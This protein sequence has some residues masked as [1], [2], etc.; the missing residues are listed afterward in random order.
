MYNM[1]KNHNTLDILSSLSTSSDTGDFY[2]TKPAGY[3]TGLTRYIVITGSVMSGLGKGIFSASLACLLQQHGY[4]CNLIKMDGYFNEDAG[5]LSPYRHG[6]VFVL[7]D[8][9]E[10]DMDIGTYERFS[11]Q[12][13]SHFNIF[14][15]GRLIKRINNLERKGHFQGGDVQFY[16]HVTGE[17]LKFVRESSLH[18]RADFTLVEIGGTVGD[19]ENRSYINAMSDLS[20]EEGP[21]N[22]FFINLV[23]I[24]EASHLNEQKTKAAQHGTQLLMQSG[25]KPDMIVCRAERHVQ[26]KVLQ[27]LGQR[28]RLKPGYV[29]DCHNLDTIYQ[30]PDLLKKQ[31][32]EERVLAHFSMEAKTV[33][34]SWEQ[35]LDL[36]LNRTKTIKIGLTGKYL[37]PRD[38]YA[39][40]HNAIEH[41]ATN[42]GVTAEIIDIPTDDIEAGK[43]DAAE[44]ITDVLGIIVPGGFGRRGAEGKIT[45]IKYA[46][47]NGVPYLGL[48]YG[49]QMAAIEYARNM[50]G[51]IR[52]DTT[53]N[54]PDTEVPLICLL[55]QQYEIEGIGGNM[56]LGGMDI[57]LKNDSQ[58]YEL[59]RGSRLLDG[60]GMIRERFRHRYELNPD[61]RKM[62]EDGGLVFSGWAPNQPI[63]QVLELPGHPFFIGVQYH[64]EFTSRPMYPNPLFYGFVKACIESQ[65]TRG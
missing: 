2:S 4:S 40:I 19:E 17:I 50:C 63:M 10:C 42:L 27:K 5:T 55:P 24:I 18:Y 3:H 56:R 21:D 59:Y 26:D 36:Y 61:Y 30:A 41:A 8:G 29:V 38:T 53:E 43:I 11:N 15:N 44:Q 14:T 64:P 9:T 52:A 7:D 49:F 37:G 23:W 12:D 28:L 47:E 13:L 33:G 39:S 32:V 57:V 34:S 16:P 31:R 48:C 58:V 62:L 65:V 1:G 22:V 54:Q 46:R 6:E 20:Y 25:I 51:S 45:C 60:R 35:Y